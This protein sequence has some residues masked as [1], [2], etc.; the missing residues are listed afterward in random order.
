[1]QD[2]SGRMEQW[3]EAPKA[4]EAVPGAVVLSG[5]GLKPEL[6]ARAWEGK[7]Q[8]QFVRRGSLDFILPMR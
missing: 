5:L 6:R 3:M 7:W 2:L 4:V 8:G 1:M